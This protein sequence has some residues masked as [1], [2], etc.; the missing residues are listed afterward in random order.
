VS[1]K[2]KKRSQHT[3]ILTNQTQTHTAKSHGVELQYQIFDTASPAGPQ[4]KVEPKPGQYAS[5]RDD[6]ASCYEELPSATKPTVVSDSNTDRLNHELSRDYVD[7]H[8]NLLWLA[9][10]FP[11]ISLDALSEETKLHAIKSTSR[12]PESTALSTITNTAIVVCDKESRQ[13]PV[14]ACNQVANDQHIIPGMPLGVAIATCKSLCVIPRNVDAEERFIKTLACEAIKLSPSVILLKDTLNI[15]ISGSI[16]LYGNL[17]AL[18]DQ[19]RSRLGLKTSVMRTACATTSEAA[20][21]FAKQG[22]DIHITDHTQLISA[23][24]ALPI[25]LLNLKSGIHKRFIGMGIECIGDLLRLPRDGLARRA[26][27]DIV[28]TLD[29]ITGRLVEP[30]NYYAPERRY[31]QSSNIEHELENLDAIMHVAGSMLEDLANALKTND[32]SVDQLVWT[33]YHEDHPPTTVQVKLSAPARDSLYFYELSLN[34]LQRFEL[35]GSVSSI[36]LSTSGYTDNQPKSLS[37][38]PDTASFS[39]DNSLIDRLRARL[40]NH[41]IQGLE[42]NDEHRPEL[43]TRYTTIG[44]HSHSNSDTTKLRSPLRPLWLLPVPRK[45]ETS[46]ALPILNGPL[47]IS[48]NQERIESGWWEVHSIRRDYYIAM[49]STG[50][51]LWIYRDLYKPENWYLHGIFG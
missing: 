24:S 9:C 11:N 39:P 50:I 32:A 19:A 14:V 4:S 20:G 22:N 26:G 47:R 37:L 18:L 12:N 25:K 31:H 49:D 29:L 3:D 17:E 34:R 16:R 42:L 48:S 51:R 33:L 7:E 38:F 13:S 8:R 36:G 23:V 2:Q 28:R 43:A 30:Q 1:R 44:K 27:T 41:A 46:N 35:P 21:L 40:G 10:Y 5:D 6:S 45:L 15:E